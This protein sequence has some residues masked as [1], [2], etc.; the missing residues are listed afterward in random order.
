MRVRLEARLQRNLYIYFLGQ[1]ARPRVCTADQVITA[2]DTCTSSM[3]TSMAM[4]RD[5]RS[6]VET[7]QALKGSSLQAESGRLDD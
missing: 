7:D 2:A 3:D 1:Q 5:V 6:S 4:A